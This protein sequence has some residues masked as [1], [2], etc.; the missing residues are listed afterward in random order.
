MFSR[1]GKSRPLI[2][3]VIPALQTLRAALEHAAN[4]DDIADICRIAAYGGGLVLDKYLNIVPEC[5][6]YEF[7]IALSPNLK[8]QWFE[9]NGR[10]STQLRRIREAVT[11]RYHELFKK[12]APSAPTP[13]SAPEPTNRGRV[14]RRFA[15]VVDPMPQIPVQIPDDIDSYFDTPPLPSLNGKTVLQ[16]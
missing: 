1:G 2:S 3:E 15:A 8:L 11:A 10:S 9:A 4:S 14:R 13:A 5:E 12:N 7:S 16:Y 6:A